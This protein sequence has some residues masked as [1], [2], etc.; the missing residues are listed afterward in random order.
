MM[1]PWP[2][3]YV[4]DGVQLQL[5]GD[6]YV[7][8]KLNETYDTVDIACLDVVA[9]L[10]LVYNDTV[11]HEIFNNQA[12]FVATATTIIKQKPRKSGLFMFSEL[13]REHRSTLCTSVLDFS[14]MLPPSLSPGLGDGGACGF[15][16]TTI[17]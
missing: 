16:I 8:E 11:L 7:Q 12:K 4:F 13:N 2:V 15:L 3:Q 17:F 9:K 6:N 1:W 14:I 10:K 5:P